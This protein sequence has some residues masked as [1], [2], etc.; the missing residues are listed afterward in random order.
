LVMTGLLGAYDLTI[1]HEKM[2]MLV[3]VIVPVHNGEKYL[4]QCLDSIVS[5]TYRNLEIITVNDGSTDNS[6]RI[7]REYAQIDSRIVVLD[8]P[9]G[10]VSSARNL[11]LDKMS[12]EYLF[13]LDVDDLI[14]SSCIEVLLASVISC[15]D[16]IAMA[17]VYRFNGNERKFED[18]GYIAKQTHM[19][20]HEFNSKLLS[21]GI[22]A[23]SWGKLMPLDVIGK[24]RFD[25]SLSHGEDLLF[26][27][28]LFQSNEVDII[29]CKEAIYEHRY[30]ARS[31]TA[32]FTSKSIF[33]NINKLIKISQ[34]DLSDDECNDFIALV[35][36][37]YW[38]LCKKISLS[39]TFSLKEKISYIKSINKIIRN[40]NLL[41]FRIF[42]SGNAKFMYR[43]LALPFSF[44]DC[45]IV[46]IVGVKLVYSI[47][48]PR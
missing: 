7:L 41:N 20:H 28:S 30:H 16:N 8:K 18:L 9:N 24:L 10:G 45:P 37:E 23:F 17:H 14:N 3:S 34:F 46:G 33:S 2:L 35:Y 47:Y 11:G 21:G 15:K 6:L 44:L 5:Q 29:L 48:N 40:D 36:S 12:G 25:T 19:S 38:N 27:V 42:N 43:I 32:Q 13:F 22:K 39:T 31:L 4:A 1:T 26:L